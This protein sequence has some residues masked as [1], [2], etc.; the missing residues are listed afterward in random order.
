[1]A[2]RPLSP[3]AAEAL[4]P[5]TAASAKAAVTAARQRNA[6]AWAAKGRPTALM[7][8]LAREIDHIILGLWTD[9]GMQ[10]ASLLAVG[11]YGRG[12]LAPYSD[13]DLLILL[14][15]QT[16]STAIE[17]ALSTFLTSLW[18]SGLD[19]GHSLRS[20]KD[21]AVQASQDLTV[22][23]ALLESRLLSG[24]ADMLERLQAQWRDGVDRHRFSEGKLL[25]MR[26]RHIRFQDTPYALEPN[27]KESPGGLRDLQVISWV[28][29]A[30][31]LGRGWGELAQ[32]GLITAHGPASF[33]NRSRCC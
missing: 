19:A 24:R 26:Q 31:G 23:T 33:S 32:A 4:A 8:Q 12:E 2:A 30:H 10:G 22:A 15:D 7:R 14:D 11:G 16:D 20:L 29:S 25:E 13:I 5:I 6:D 1:M 18:D 3:S 9:A 27:V 28:A 17:G 21:C